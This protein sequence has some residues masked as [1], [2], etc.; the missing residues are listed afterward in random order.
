MSKDNKILPKDSA[1]DFSLPGRFE[2]SNPEYFEEVIIKSKTKNRGLLV[3]AIAFVIIASGFF[4]YYFIYQEEI[5]SKIIQNSPIL[6]PEQRLVNQYGVGAYGSE[7]SHAAIVIFVNDEYLNFSLPQFQLLSKYIHFENHNPYL[8][9]KHATDVPLEMLFAS[10]GM[11]I[12]RD[13]L[14]LNYYESEKIK[15]GEFCSDQNNTLS[16][17]VN[18]KPFNSDLSKYVFDHNDRILISFGEIDSIPKQLDYLESLTIFDVPKNVPKYS[19][20][21][22]TI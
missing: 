21:G 10:M 9:H 11:K 6:D 2:E 5:D 18:G 8:I 12:T 17:F 7:H 19:G 15:T 4:S 16:F 13:C 3:M 22:I 20:D 14:L 1:S